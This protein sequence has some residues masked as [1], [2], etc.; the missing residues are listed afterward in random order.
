MLLYG[1]RALV[2]RACKQ[3]GPS[4]PFAGVFLD[5]VRKTRL[6]FLV[7]LAVELVQGYLHPPQDVAKTVAFLFTVAAALQV[8]IWA[9]RP[10]PRHDRL[11]APATPKATTAASPARWAS[12]GC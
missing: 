10:D 12:S 9:R 5:V 3:L 7:A 11:A 4:H 1:V 6:W 2:L 8:A